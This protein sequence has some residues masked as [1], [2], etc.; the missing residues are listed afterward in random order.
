ME[1]SQEIKFA[2]AAF[3]IEQYN[4]IH[5]NELRDQPAV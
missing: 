5:Y 3:L 1:K 2:V 4:G